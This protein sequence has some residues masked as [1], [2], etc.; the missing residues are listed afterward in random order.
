MNLEIY[1]SVMR[2][3][4]E[5]SYPD[6]LWNSIFKRI[7]SKGLIIND[8][9]RSKTEGILDLTVFK[10]NTQ[11][12]KCLFDNLNSIVKNCEEFEYDRGYRYSTL[13]KYKQINRDKLEGLI[14]CG[15]MIPFTE[16]DQPND[17]L[18]TH[19]A[20][21]TVKYDNNKI[22]LKFSLELRSKLE[23]QRNLKHTILTVI[24]LDNKTIEVRQ[25]IIPL[26]YKLNEK[27]YVSNV[28]SVRSWLETQLEVHV[29]EI[30]LQAIT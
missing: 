3:T 10:D 29:E 22:Y 23:D 1:K 13:Y 19:I 28:K 2:W 24:N 18:I 17:M 5:K 26:E 25:D 15:K 7:A 20:Y 6:Y 16:D 14:Q 21:P 12:L 8:G 11:K 27:A 4:I 9:R 30:D